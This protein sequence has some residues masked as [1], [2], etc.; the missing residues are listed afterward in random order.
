MGYVTAVV[1]DA[2]ACAAAASARAGVRIVELTTVEQITELGAV[3]QK[4]WQSPS[5]HQVADP[6]LVKALA[7]AGNYVVGAYRDRIM[8]GASWAFLGRHEPSA[9]PRSGSTGMIGELHLHS[10]ITGVLPG[11]RGGAGFAI[12]QHQRA[13]A[14]ARGIREVHWTFDPLIR[15]NA[16]FNL[17]KLGAHVTGYLPDFYGPM[18]DGINTGDTTDR[19][20]VVWRLDSPAAVAAAHDEPPA[21]GAAQGTGPQLLA[22]GAG[23]PLLWSV[24]GEPVSRP[25]DELAGAPALLVETPQDAEE[26]R[27]SDPERSARWR[28]EVRFSLAMA[29]AA[30][31][32]LVGMTRDGSY[33]LRR[34][35]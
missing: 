22:T 15:R 21:A 19:L 13:W 7:Y 24:D 35:V 34:S 4:V 18:A 16:H 23:E 9:G 14:L 10:H 28:Q 32:Q 12:K 25:L 1:A 17:H 5:V 2:Q 20:Y 6:G 11:E 8:V 33:E 3:L 30:G 27:A 26:L 31:Y 29:F